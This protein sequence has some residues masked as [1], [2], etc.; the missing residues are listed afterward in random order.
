M[1]LSTDEIELLKEVEEQGVDDFYGPV[2][3]IAFYRFQKET[4]L[5]RQIPTETIGKLIVGVWND[6]GMYHEA[7]DEPAQGGGA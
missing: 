7:E 6:I 1:A 2:L 4:K 3:A 5:S